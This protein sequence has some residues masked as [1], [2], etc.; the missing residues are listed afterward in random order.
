MVHESPVNRDYSDIVARLGG[1]RN[2]ETSSR[3]TKAFLRARV[4]ANAVDLLRLILAYCLGERGLRSAAAWASG[5]GFVDI[6]SVA[7][8]Y[9]LRQCGD[10]LSLL[11]G[12]TLAFDAPEAAQGRLIRLIDATTA[13]KA[14]AHLLMILLLEPLE[15]ELEDSRRW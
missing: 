4:I 10:W 2:L 15:D 3:E 5:V 6:S 11:V 9:R 13:P 1:A 14:G 8:L 7:R 12:Q